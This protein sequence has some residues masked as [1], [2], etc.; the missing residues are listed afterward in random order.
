MLQYDITTIERQAAFLAQVAHESGEFSIMKEA[1]SGEAYEGRIDLG[2]KFPGDGVKYKGRGPLQ[3]TG[4]NNYFFCSKSI[5][6]NDRL[7]NEPELLELPE[8]GCQSAGWYWHDRSLNEIADKPDNWL[9][10][11]KG[12]PYDRFQWITVK[13]NGGLNGYPQR[14]HYY[15]ILRMNLKI[16]PQ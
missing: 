13:I 4:R 14:L 5:F 6:G 9:Q 7:L 15:Q 16:N 2:N 1:A 12:R 8:Y 10:T 11:W 3:I